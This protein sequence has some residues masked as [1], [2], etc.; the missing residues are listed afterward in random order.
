MREMSPVIDIGLPDLSS[1][2]L[3]S[4][5]EECENE[6][7][8]YILKEIPGKSLE[9]FFVICMLELEDELHLTIDINIVQRYD[10]GHNLEE[11]IDNASQFG[12]DWLEKRLKELK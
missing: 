3:D 11:V 12:S 9:D 4:L 7:S 5:T 2:Q 10:T 1:D 8:E 6:I